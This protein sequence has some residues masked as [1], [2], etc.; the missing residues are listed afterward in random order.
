[1]VELLVVIGLIGLLLAFLFPSMATSLANARAI[2]CQSNVRVICQQLIGYASTNRGRF[3]ANVTSPAA[4][5]YQTPSLA[6]LTPNPQN[7]LRDR[8]AVCPEDTGSVRSYAMNVWSSSKMDG[9]IR[10][11]NKDAPWALATRNSSKL[12]LLAETWSAQGS[13]ATGWYAPPYIGS[14]DASPGRR[15]GG[16][17]GINY[18]AGRFGIVQSELDFSRHRLVG[19]PRK[20]GDSV[21]RTVIGY[22]DGH[23][24]LQTNSELVTLAGTSALQAWWSPSDPTLNK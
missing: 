23:V 6:S 3:P 1:L 8:I 18:S 11:N 22:A 21:G 13:A 19:R 7:E 2:Q 16:A 5:W 15:F 9:V 10:T 12:L 14:T 20:T 4:W 17:G 24:M